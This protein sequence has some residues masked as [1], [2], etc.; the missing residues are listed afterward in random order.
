MRLKVLSSKQEGLSDILK[1][2]E[3]VLAEASKKPNYAEIIKSLIVQVIIAL[4]SVC[5]YKA[6]L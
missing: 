6:M 2:S 4:S 3:A 5:V 1:N